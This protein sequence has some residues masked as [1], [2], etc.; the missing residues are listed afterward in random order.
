MG[1][2]RVFAREF[3]VPRQPLAA[4]RESLPFQVQ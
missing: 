4:I 1:G 3:G 2:S